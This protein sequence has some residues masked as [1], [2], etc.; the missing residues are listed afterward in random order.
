MCFEDAAT[1]LKKQGIDVGDT[2]QCA[3]I[4]Q[5]ITSI[6]RHNIIHDGSHP[7]DDMIDLADVGGN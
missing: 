5:S 2:A 4:C 7:M 1:R 6:A 3:V